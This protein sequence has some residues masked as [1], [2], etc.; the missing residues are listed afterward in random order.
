MKEK[1]NSDSGNLLVAF[2]PAIRKCC[3]K[4]REDFKKIFPGQVTGRLGRYYLDLAAVNKR[5]VLDTGVP[6]QNL[7][8]T[9]FCTCCLNENLFSFRC[10]GLSCGRM[11]SVMMLK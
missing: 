5:Q 4:V 10:E 6:G 3:Y 2:G 8:D 11:M 7:F 9:G 1:F